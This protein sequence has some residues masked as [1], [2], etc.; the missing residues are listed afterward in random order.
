MALVS[1]GSAYHNLERL[2]DCWK[3]VERHPWDEVSS[4]RAERWWLCF[5]LSDAG[6]LYDCMLR[7]TTCRLKA[8]CR[9]D[10]L[11]LMLQTSFLGYWD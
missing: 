9:Y 7:M 1:S 6:L 3:T 11:M 10:G 8:S 2:R 4:C 5:L